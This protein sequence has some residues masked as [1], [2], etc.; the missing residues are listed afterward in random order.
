VAAEWR[1]SGIWPGFRADAPVRQLPTSEWARDV[2]AAAGQGRPLE[3]GSRLFSIHV[4]L[5]F[6]NRPVCTYRFYMGG[7]IYREIKAPL[8][9]I[10]SRLGVV[11]PRDLIAEAGSSRL[12]PRGSTGSALGHISNFGLGLTHA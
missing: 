4:P 8:T 11:L 9:Y 3:F 12:L 1:L 6:V 2:R 5:L 10:E 7:G